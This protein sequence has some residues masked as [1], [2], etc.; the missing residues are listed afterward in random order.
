[1][2]FQTPKYVVPSS[3]VRFCAHRS[4]RHICMLPGQRAKLTGPL[5]SHA[6]YHRGG[7]FTRALSASPRYLAHRDEWCCS[8]PPHCSLVLAG[9]ERS[10]CDTCLVRE[11]L[12]ASGIDGCSVLGL[13]P[14][15]LPSGVARVAE[16]RVTVE[17]S[18]LHS[19]LRRPTTFSK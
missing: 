4:Y 2:G 1:M 13:L 10:G 5:A 17:K 18:P 8:A 11:R 6:I 3:T 16:R 19:L 7:R 15:A 14:V 12:V 9:R